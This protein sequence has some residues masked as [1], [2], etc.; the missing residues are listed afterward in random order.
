MVVVVF[1]TYPQAINGI[2]ALK[3]LDREG[4]I[5]VHSASVIKKSSEGATELLKTEDE[6]PIHSVWGT[7]I[8]SVVGLLGGP[9]GVVL[10]ASWG[11]V[12]GG[13]HD[14]HRSEVSVEFV[15]EVSS[16]LTPGKFALVAD[17]SEEWITPLDV[18]MESLGGQVFRTRKRYVEV[19]QIKAD[20]A[21]FNAEIAQLN[22]EMK[23]VRGEQKAKLQ[24]KVE[25]LKVKRQERMERAKKQLEQ[26]KKERDI[27]VEALKKKASNARGE[28]KAAME[29]RVT[30]IN[31]DY[32]EIVKGWSKWE[33]GWTR[34]LSN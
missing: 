32:Q 20:V 30:Q 24:A 4:A 21:T 29:A 28:T 8:G 27:K 7:A 15:D 5:S 1:D 31:K 19:D 22:E 6:F 23:N 10:G 33:I 2:L 18:K 13:L 34:R 16:S 26:M 17:I 25:K 11:A 9:V 14:L 12:L 3:Q